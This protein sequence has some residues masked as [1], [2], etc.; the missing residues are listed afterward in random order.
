VKLTQNFMRPTLPKGVFPQL[1]DQAAFFDRVNLAIEGHCRRRAGLTVQHG[2]SIPIGGPERPY[3]RAIHGTCL[4]TGN[5]FELRYGRNR[6]FRNLPSFSLR[7]RSD[8]CPL[9]CDEVAVVTSALFRRG[10]R[11]RPM[12]LELT[13]DVVGTTVANLRNSIMSSLRW[14]RH[15]CDEH[16]AQTFYLGSPYSPLQIWIYDKQRP[17]IVR[18]EAVLR[19]GFLRAPTILCAA[20]PQP[21]GR[22]SSQHAR[23]LAEGHVA[24]LAQPP[25]TSVV[26]LALAPPEGGSSASPCRF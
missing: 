20:E 16:G 11:L 7:F 8:I 15:L 1:I 12:L 22:R 9:T 17:D 21:A 25:P 2:S 26:G 23:G 24:G 14:E 10:F 18:I 19:A 3:A 4:R 13:F 5:P 6:M